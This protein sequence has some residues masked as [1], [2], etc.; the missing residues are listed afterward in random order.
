MSELEDYDFEICTERIRMMFPDGYIGKLEKLQDII[1]H[2]QWRQVAEILSKVGFLVYEEKEVR[3]SKMVTKVK[4]Y[5]WKNVSDQQ[6][7]DYHTKE[8]IDGFMNPHVWVKA[9][10][11]VIQEK[12]GQWKM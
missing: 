9:V 7:W 12:G 10:Q 5:S 8:T 11:R 1:S 4:F 3:H 6:L 2:P